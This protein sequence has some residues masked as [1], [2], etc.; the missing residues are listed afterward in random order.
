MKKLLLPAVVLSSIALFGCQSTGSG[1]SSV[2]K[3]N[4]GVTITGLNDS[5]EPTVEIDTLEF[6]KTGR[7]PFTGDII[8]SMHDVWLREYIDKNSKISVTQI[9][10]SRSDPT[11]ISWDRL[12]FLGEGGLV[13]LNGN[14]VGHDIDVGQYGT[15]HVRD[16]VF[17]V[18][19]DLLIFLANSNDK[20]I[21]MRLS[22]TTSSARETVKIS[23]QEFRNLL[24]ERKRV[25]EKM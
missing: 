2:S 9:Y 24:D 4:T 18:S 12:A 25:L 6:Q 13:T 11:S 10:I 17:P 5:L 20:E 8:N 21:E 1:S 23:P 3:T 15:R 19:D 22:S 7:V 14:Q 16:I